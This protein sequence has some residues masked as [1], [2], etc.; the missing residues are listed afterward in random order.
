MDAG[1][2][3]PKTPVVASTPPASRVRGTSTN[4]SRQSAP[5]L[6]PKPE[7]NPT[8]NLDSKTSPGT[9]KQQKPTPKTVAANKTPVSVPKETTRAKRAPSK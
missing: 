5:T 7:H 3:S 4:V 6:S 2:Q 9:I 8:L 1:H